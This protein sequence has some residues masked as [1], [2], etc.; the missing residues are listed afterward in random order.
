MK[1]AH[2]ALLACL[3]ATHLHAQ[4]LVVGLGYAD[5]NN[6]A[7]ENGAVLQVEYHFAP[8]WHLGGGE[9]HF[10]VAAMTNDPGDYFIGAGL[11]AAFPLGGKG[12]FVQGS[13]IPGY[14]DAS[15]AGNELGNDLE[16]RSSLA[17]GYRLQSGW[18]ISASATHM[19]NA[20]IGDSNP[21][22]TTASLRLGRS[23]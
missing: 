8:R 19:S 3:S 7:A 18:A 9:V 22:V 14:Y 20:G 5:F 1:I 12:W 13:V 11:G 6:N 17:L 4:E 21:G 2:V 23:F 15:S 10:V 16:F